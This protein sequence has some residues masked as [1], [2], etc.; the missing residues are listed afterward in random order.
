MD[1]DVYRLRLARWQRLVYEANTSGMKKTEWCRINGVSTKQF[2]YWQKKVRAMALDEMTGENGQEKEG[3]EPL[4]ESRL[5]AFVE[6]RPPAASGCLPDGG[7]FLQ[8]DPSVAPLTLQFGR[9]QLQI[10]ENAS[11]SMLRMAVRVLGDA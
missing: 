8:E 3:Q 5:P 4:A 7:P 10:R 1:I 9:F 11:E 2:Y 6:L